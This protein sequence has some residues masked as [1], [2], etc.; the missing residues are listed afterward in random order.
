MFQVAET[1][2]QAISATDLPGPRFPRDPA[3]T[4]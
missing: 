3:H 1:V 4:I 2:S